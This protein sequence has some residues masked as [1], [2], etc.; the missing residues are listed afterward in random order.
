MHSATPHCQNGHTT[1][2]KQLIATDCN[3]DLQGNDGATVCATVLQF[4]EVQGHAGI[5]TLTR[6][7]NQETPM[8]VCRVLINRLVT[9]PSSTANWH[10]GELRRRQGPTP[11]CSVTLCSLL[12][13]LVVFIV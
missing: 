3:I 9:S 12:F 1:V 6:N 13:S 8:L 5:A 2:T 4:A 11:V 10:G 7:R